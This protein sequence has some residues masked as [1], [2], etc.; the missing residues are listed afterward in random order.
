MNKQTAIKL[1]SDSVWIVGNSRT[2]YQVYGPWDGLNPNGATTAIQTS[3]YKLA[4]RRSSG[5]KAFIALVLLGADKEK[6][7]RVEQEIVE[8]TERIDWRSMVA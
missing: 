3:S 5:W 7:F 2:G 1:A 8:S 4:Q 6:A